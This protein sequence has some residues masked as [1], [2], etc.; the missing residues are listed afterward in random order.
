VDMRYTREHGLS[1]H[2]TSDELALGVDIFDALRR[3]ALARRLLDAGHALLHGPHEGLLL[4]RAAC[5]A[6]ILSYNSHTQ[7]TQ[8]TRDMRRNHG[9]FRSGQVSSQ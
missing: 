8:I 2:D 5:V 7:A 9:A 6:Y 1:W 4:E 3:T